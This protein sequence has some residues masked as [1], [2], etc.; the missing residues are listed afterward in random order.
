MEATKL[1]VLCAV[2][3]RHGGRHRPAPCGEWQDEMS[4]FLSP[5]GEW[6]FNLEL[7]EIGG[8]GVPSCF[9]SLLGARTVTLCDSESLH[10]HTA[11]SMICQIVEN[12]CHCPA[13]NAESFPPHKFSL[14]TMRDLGERQRILSELHGP[15]FVTGTM[16]CPRNCG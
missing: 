12:L 6:Y 10:I 9:K 3:T 1:T 2:G 4:L 14:L 13:I 11:V 7:H 16:S 8:S 5:S 15:C